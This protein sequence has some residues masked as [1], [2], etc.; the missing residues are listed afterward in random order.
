MMRIIRHM[1]WSWGRGFLPQDL[2]ALR[3]WGS[4]YCLHGSQ[5]IEVPDRSAKSKHEATSM[6]RCGKGLLLLNPLSPGEGQYGGRC[7]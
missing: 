5:V 1:I 6:V 7:S 4:L 2:A 3:I